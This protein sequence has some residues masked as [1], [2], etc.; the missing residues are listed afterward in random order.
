[1]DSRRARVLLSLSPLCLAAACDEEG[2]SAL[3]AE[4]T[5]E[6]APSEGTIEAVIGIGRLDSDD[7]GGVVCGPG[8][9][10]ARCGDD[11]A[12]VWVIAETDDLG[13]K[14]IK[15]VVTDKHGRFVI[16]DLPEEA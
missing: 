10:P 14:L 7:I 2:S 11:F 12:G 8:Q 6:P 15:T 16:P 3:V 4:V 13:T 5:A 1:M 9:G